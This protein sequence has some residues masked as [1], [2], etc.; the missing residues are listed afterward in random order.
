MSACQHMLTTRAA[1]SWDLGGVATADSFSS[2]LS[3][4]SITAMAFAQKDK[5]LLHQWFPGT[6]NPFIASAPM[7][8]H[9]DCRLAAAVTNAGGLGKPASP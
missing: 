3:H 8:G 2:H 5:D 7:L 4:A 6:M 9:T 1:Y